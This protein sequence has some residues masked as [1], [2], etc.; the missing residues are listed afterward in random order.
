M[1][2]LMIT[3]LGSASD[4][5]SGKKGAFY[6]TLE[7]F[8]EYWERIDIIAP[9]IAKHELRI[10]NLFGNVYIHISP[11]P[12]V[13]HPIWFLKKGLEIYREQKFDLMTV[14]EFPPFYNGIG[15]RLLWRK[16]R[17]PYILEI[18]HIPGYPKAANLKERI[19]KTLMRWFIKTD[20][21]KAKAVRVVNQ[22]QVPEFLVKAGVP[23]EKIIYIPSA[24]LD[25]D[26]FK[27]IDLSKE[28]DLMFLG[29]LEKNKGI[30]LL[31]RAVEFSISNL[32][33]P[34]K[35]M[36]V[37]QGSLFASLNSEVKS[38][39]L[40]NNVI[41]HGWAKD[42]REVAELMNKSKILVMPS[43]NEGGPR[44]VLEAM[45]CGVPVLA[46]PVGIVPD[47]IKDRESGRIVG[48]NAKDIALKA[49]ELLSGME[50]YN[51]YRQAGLEISKQFEKKA[52]I[53]NY[54][55]KLS[56]I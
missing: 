33:F 17:V 50:E 30:E 39:K 11:W 46:T 34:M 38:L 14:Q 8:H 21:A 10:T 19:Y 26:V 47:V 31:L 29:R 4:L 5:A 24:Y 9:R 13:F 32:Q 3:G 56:T 51:K 35:C 43:Y 7:E 48:W 44:V 36:I 28:Y 53:K 12:L 15:A 42:S 23:K 40:E 18:H 41:F 49:K 27:P 1:K 6:N 37:G 54:A 55:E 52:A 2:L 25:L 22:K 16:I 20:S 45:A